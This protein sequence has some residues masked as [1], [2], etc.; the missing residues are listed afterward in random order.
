MS[1]AG[2]SRKTTPFLDTFKAK[3]RAI[4][5]APHTFPSISSL[6]T[7]L[8][9]HNHG[10]YIYGKVKNFDVFENF[11]GIKKSVLTLPEI[12]LNFG[13]DI[14]FF[15]SIDVARYP[16]KGRLIPKIFPHDTPAEK[17]LNDALRGI[18]K[19]KMHK[20]FLAYVHLGDLHEPV[21]PP[22]AFK[23]YFGRVKPLPRVN[24]WAFRRPNE[25]SGDRF[26]EYKYNRILLYDNTIRYVD[27]AIEQFYSKIEEKG[28]LDSTLL[29]ITADHGEEFWEHAKLEAKNFYDP[30]GYYGVGHGHNVFNEIIEVPIL[31]SGLDIPKFFKKEELISSVDIVPTI[32]SIL[33]VSHNLMLDGHNLFKDI[34]RRYILSEAAGYGYEKKALFLGEYK[35]IYSKND[36]VKWLFNLKNDPSE[37]YPIVDDKV[38]AIFVK[39]LEE[40]LR[41]DLIRRKLRAVLTYK[42][43]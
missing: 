30:R 39:K 40:I 10:A 37:Q 35:L 41:N 38:T 26:E 1:F 29:I 27:Y 18:L 23:D 32:L 36:N 8:Y 4:S 12:L 2:Y 19:N 43:K 5:A 31:I 21:K 33:G 11:R 42:R 16:L 13:Y 7:G 3:F 22:K 6:L 15:T 20:P 24:E 9:P 28:L 34:K 17:L 25:Q 14:Y